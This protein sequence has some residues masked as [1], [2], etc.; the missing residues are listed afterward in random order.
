[1]IAK[2]EEIVICRSICLSNMDIKLDYLPLL[3][4]TIYMRKIYNP[5][6]RKGN[7]FLCHTNSKFTFKVPFTLNESKTKSDISN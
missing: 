5:P 7:F 1:M 3:V 2:H 6:D 4:V